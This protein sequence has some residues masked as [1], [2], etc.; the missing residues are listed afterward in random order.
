M[1]CFSI[2]KIPSKRSFLKGEL[3]SWNELYQGKICEMGKMLPSL[4]A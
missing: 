2:L 4:T 3:K 1:V